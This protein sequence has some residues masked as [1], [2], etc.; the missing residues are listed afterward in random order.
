MA[1]GF[2]EEEILFYIGDMTSHAHVVNGLCG[3]MDV[4]LSY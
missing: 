2:A 1:I 4:C 3:I